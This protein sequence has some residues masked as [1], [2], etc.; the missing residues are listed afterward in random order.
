MSDC[1][2]TLEAPRRA[3]SAAP[4]SRSPA[5]STPRV[6]AAVAA[7]RARR[8]AR[9]RSPPS[10]PPSP[11]GELDGARRVA[12]AHR[13]RATRRS[14]TDELARDGLPRATAPTAATSA[15][16][17]STTRSP[18]S[19]P[20]R[21]YAALLSGANADDAGRLAPRPA[22]GRRARRRPPAARRRT[23]G[24]RSARSRASFALP[25]AEKPAT[26]CLASR[27]PYG[28]AVDP[29]TLAQID[30]AERAVRALG[31]PVLRVRHHGILG[32]RSRSPPSDL[33]ARARRASRRSSPPIKRRRLRARRDRPRAVPLRP[34][35]RG[36]SA[37]RSIAVSAA[38]EARARLRRQR[39]LAEQPRAE[40]RVGEVRRSPRRRRAA[41]ARPGRA[42]AAAPPRPRA[43]RNATARSRNGRMCSAIASSSRPPPSIASR[44]QMTTKSWWVAKNSK[45]ASTSAATRSKPTGAAD[46][47]QRRHR[48]PVVH[49]LLDHRGVQPLLGAE[50]VEQRRVREARA[51]GD[52]LQARGVAVLGELPARRLEDAVRARPS[53]DTLVETGGTVRVCPTTRH[54]AT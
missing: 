26:P 19:P 39:V 33:D 10:R 40:A 48:R 13:H 5:A 28:T 14:R 37:S 54:S 38:R 53:T 7:P 4:S 36:A 41:S 29:E 12:A 27:I 24:R 23:Q 50:V 6:V 2:P 32:P 42:R 9:S 1:S 17:S 25:S 20:A 11:Q 51:L 46:T 16:P 31:F 35:Q 22:R 34:A 43:R 8:R 21:G 52:V 18:S 44:R 15:R 3:R 45:P 30:R 49:R 47:A